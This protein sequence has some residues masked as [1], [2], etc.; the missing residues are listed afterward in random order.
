V[1]LIGEP[2]ERAYVAD[3]LARLAAPHRS[4]AHNLA[5]EL[6]L[7]GLLA[8]LS[9]A[10][11][12]VTNDTGPM[13][14]AWA[15]NTPAVRLFGPGDPQHYGIDR[16]NSAIL[17]KALYCRPCLYATDEPRCRS[18]NLCMQRISVD[19]VVAAIERLLAGNHTAHPEPFAPEFFEDAT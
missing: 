4:R 7:G 18:N 2:S 10:R 14:M 9:E 12:L 17:Y 13:H 16:A 1:L 19:E 6:S 11:C 15:L 8:L 3:V 5:G